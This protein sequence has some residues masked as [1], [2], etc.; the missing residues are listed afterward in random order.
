VQATSCTNDDH[1]SHFLKF[2][3]LSEVYFF[4]ENSSDSQR[5]FWTFCA[6]CFTV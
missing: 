2:Q 4:L 6:C 1:L 3:P 5:S